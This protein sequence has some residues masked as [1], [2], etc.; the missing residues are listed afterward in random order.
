MNGPLTAMTSALVAAVL[1]AT[2]AFAD[3]LN[4]PDDFVTIQAAIDAAVDGCEIVVADGT[5][6]GA[7]NRDLDFGGQAITLRSA[8]RPDFARHH[9]PP[10]PPVAATGHLGQDR[11]ARPPDGRLVVLHAPSR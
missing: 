11:A 7:G 8:N 9:L 4:V 6:T 3:T 10:P 5:Y 1:A 2:S